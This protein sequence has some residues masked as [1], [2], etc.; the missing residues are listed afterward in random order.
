ME[1]RGLESAG[2]IEMADRWK[3]TA[4]VRIREMNTLS[5]QLLVSEGNAS[6]SEDALDGV[7]PVSSKFEKF[8]RSS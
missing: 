3:S 6:T 2:F 4:M 5:G 1:S 7:W 8:E